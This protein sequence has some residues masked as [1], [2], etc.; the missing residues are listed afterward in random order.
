ML[1]GVG[2]PWATPPDDAVLYPGIFSLVVDDAGAKTR[3][4]PS[5]YHSYAQIFAHRDLGLVLTRLESLIG[6]VLDADARASYLI[7]ACRVGDTYGL[8]AR[9]VFNRNSFRIAARR[10]G[11][12][13][14]DE[15][16]VEMVPDGSFKC[17][18]WGEFQPRFVVVS[19][20]TSIAG[21]PDGNRGAQLT[22]LFG[23]LRVG[24]MTAFALRRVSELVRSERVLSEPDP[25]LLVE[26]IKAIPPA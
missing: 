17:D 1:D 25:G 18:T 7:T 11:L 9:D 12:E 4:L 24:D 6:R 3:R 10:A 5:V 8:Y 2:A 16:H 22:F 26:S 13:L 15:P 23:I 19:D 21:T 20:V 14:A